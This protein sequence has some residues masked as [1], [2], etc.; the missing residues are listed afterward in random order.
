MFIN[1]IFFVPFALKVKQVCF[2]IYEIFFLFL[3]TLFKNTY[4]SMLPEKC[5]FFSIEAILS[6]KNVQRKFLKAYL[7]WL[8]L[9]FS[10]YWYKMVSMWLI[11]HQRL[12]RTWKISN[13]TN[14]CTEKKNSKCG[15]EKSLN[16][17]SAIFFSS[18]DFWRQQFERSFAF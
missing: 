16:F 7:K 17:Y 13:V 12:Y 9:F 2:S 11:C 1:I 8:E 4:Y 6:L 18:R 10:Y 3:R 5:F 15:S 14:T